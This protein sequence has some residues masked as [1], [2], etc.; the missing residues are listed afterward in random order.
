MG[1]NKLITASNEVSGIAD[2]FSIPISLLHFQK[3]ILLILFK[4][5][6]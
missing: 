1:F 3:S 5:T 6:A 2:T 4:Q